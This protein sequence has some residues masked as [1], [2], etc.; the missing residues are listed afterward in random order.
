MKRLIRRTLRS[1]G[2][3]LVR[4]TPDSGS[5]FANLQDLS[6]QQRNTILAARPFTMTSVE[7]MTALINAVTYVVENDI[8]GDIA[9]CGVW[10]GG[11]MMTI[12]LTL[13]AHGDRSRALYLYDTFEGMSAPTADDKSLAGISADELLKKD[14]PGTGIWCYASLDDVRANLLSTGYPEDRIHLIKGKVEDTI[15][16]TLP[17]ELAILRLDTDW[18]ESTKHELIHLYPLLHSDGIL[19][20]DDYG[21]WQGAR[22]AVDEYFREQG[23]RVFL[24]RIDYTGRLL[25]KSSSASRARGS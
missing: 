17:S 16:Q 15:P 8:P 19:V 2:F 22:K 13:L 24:H 14:R 11:S 21:H 5:E 7:R 18:Y 1:L 10:R 20:I 6:A 12:A 9:E 4:Y 25:V 3:D 23:Q